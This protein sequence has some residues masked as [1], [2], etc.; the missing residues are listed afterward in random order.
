MSVFY[1][2]VNDKNEILAFSTVKTVDCLNLEFNESDLTKHGISPKGS[3]SKLSNSFVKFKIS[4]KEIV[5]EANDSFL[6]YAL[7]TN[8]K[9]SMVTELTN[10]FFVKF[11]KEER[12]YRCDITDQLTIIQALAIAEEDGSCD[13]KCEVGGSSQKFVSHSLSECKIVNL[14]MSRHILSL[15]KRYEERKSEAK[16]KTLDEVGNLIWRE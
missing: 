4:N 9:L 7:N 10:G 8:I 12:F 14:E 6:R 15:R 2:I 11:G 5:K 13:I 1:P 3:Y 16:N